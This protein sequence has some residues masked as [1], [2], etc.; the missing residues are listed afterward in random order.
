MALKS[1]GT[2]VIKELSES[3]FLTL[4]VSSFVSQT[5]V[6]FIDSFSIFKAI[7]EFSFISSLRLAQDSL[8][9]KLIREVKMPFESVLSLSYFPYKFSIWSISFI[10]ITL[11]LVVFSFLLTEAVEFVMKE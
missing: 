3:L 1:Y 6:V 10:E 2:V 9:V 4:F 11:E 5:V 7:F 8:S